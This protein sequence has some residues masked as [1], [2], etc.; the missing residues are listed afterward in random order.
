MN[1]MVSELDV[2]RE[3]LDWI[4][5][6]DDIELDVD[7]VETATS[8]LVTGLVSKLDVE[9]EMLDWTAVEDDVEVDSDTLETIT[10]TVVNAV[11]WELVVEGEILDWTAVTF[12]IVKGAVIFSLAWSIGSFICATVAFD[13]VLLNM[14]SKSATTLPEE[15]EITSTLIN[16]GRCW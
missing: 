2:G 5:I 7:T 10:P 3:T 4:A 12:R 13:S 1:G 15:N 6:D 8:R 11:A 14:T 16:P 9:G